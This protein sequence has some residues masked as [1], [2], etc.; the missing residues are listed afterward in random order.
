MDFAQEIIPKIKFFDIFPESSYTLISPFFSAQKY[1]KDDTVL[2]QGELNTQLYFLIKG[3]VNIYIDD[4]YVVT[5]QGPGEVFGEMSIAGHTTCTA[6]VSAND[7][8][9]FAIF[10]YTRIK[11]LPENQKLKVECAL[12]KS[13]AEVLANKLINTNEIARTYK[14]ISEN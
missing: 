10:D 2:D 13:C 3:S 9:I 8:C 1:Q 4:E 14:M 7:E 12:F 11:E 6:K 5:L